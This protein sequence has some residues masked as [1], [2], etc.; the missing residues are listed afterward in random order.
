MKKHVFLFN[1]G[2][3]A[4][5][6]GIGTY[7]RQMVSC[8]TSM[9]DVVLHLVLFHSE[10]EKVTLSQQDRYDELNLPRSLFLLDGKSSN[11]YR[12]A[13]RLVLLYIPIAENNWCSFY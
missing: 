10:V 4:A 3:R 7:I 9:E 1:Q 12:N 11:Y 6:Y 8:L 5:V 2:S 13:W